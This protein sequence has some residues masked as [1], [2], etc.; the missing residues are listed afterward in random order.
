[1]RICRLVRVAV[2]VI[3]DRRNA[4]REPDLRSEYLPECVDDQRTQPLL[5]LEPGEVARHRDDRGAFHKSDRAGL[6]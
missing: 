3:G 5:E 2:N 1:M 6:R 4:D